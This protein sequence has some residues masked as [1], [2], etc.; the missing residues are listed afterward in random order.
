ML[1]R[2]AGRTEPPKRLNPAALDTRTLQFQSENGFVQEG[3]LPISHLTFGSF[4]DFRLKVLAH[5]AQS[6]FQL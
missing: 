3:S 5:A 4:M 6:S 1:C 2:A